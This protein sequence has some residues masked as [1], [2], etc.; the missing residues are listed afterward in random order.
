[1]TVPAAGGRRAPA[2]ICRAALGVM[3]LGALVLGVWALGA[4]ASFY[5]SFPGFG[6]FWVSVDGPYNEHLVR[7]VGSLNLALF[8]VTGAAFVLVGNRALVLTAAAANAAFAVPHLL[9][10]FGHRH[11]L[12]APGDQVGELASLL[13]VV[14]AAAVAALTATTAASGGRALADRVDVV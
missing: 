8:T 7:D 12:V 1:M 11:D 13:L 9:Y 2:F 3:A 10:H 4:P 5:D 14:V 6:R